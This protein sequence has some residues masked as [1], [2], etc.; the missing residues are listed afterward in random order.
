VPVPAN[1]P[2]DDVQAGPRLELRVLKPL[3]RIEL[4]MTAAGVVEDLGQHPHDV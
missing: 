3:G 1:I 4:A 2:V